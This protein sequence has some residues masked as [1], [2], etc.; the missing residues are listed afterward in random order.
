MN[1]WIV[2]IALIAGANAPRLAPALPR[3]ER[4]PGERALVAAGGAGLAAICLLVLAVAGDP[5]ASWWEVSAPTVAVA[6]GLVLVLATIASVARR[7]RAEPA[8]PGRRAV[9][10]PVAVPFVLRP[11][12][13]LVCLAAGAGDQ[14]PAAAGGLAVI[15]ASVTVAALAS[16]DGPSRRVVAW[17]AWGCQVA[18]IAAGIAITVDGVLAV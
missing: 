5:I 17:A 3:G 9:L 8:L 2:A 11:E 12:L 18:T 10:V 1:A 6:A 7:P 15:V 16:D 4:S 13:G 14:L